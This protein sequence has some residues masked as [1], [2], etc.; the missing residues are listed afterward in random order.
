MFHVQHARETE[1]RAA[2]FH[3]LKNIHGSIYVAEKNGDNRSKKL[4]NTEDLNKLFE[5]IIS[6]GNI[7][8]K[9]K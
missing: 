5:T 1:Q 7:L 8:Q 4:K 3:K 9:I 6:S 2:K